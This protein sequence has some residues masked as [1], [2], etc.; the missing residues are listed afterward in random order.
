MAKR[1]ADEI[2]ADSGHHVDKQVARRS[3]QLFNLRANIQQ[4]PHIE[5]DMENAAVEEHGSYKSP[6]L[7][8]VVRQRQGRAQ[9]LQNVA[10]DSPKVEKAGETTSRH[11]KP[12]LAHCH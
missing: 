6:R 7:R 2:S 8:K 4:H 1:T 5:N 3:V 10:A 9:A 12:A 11:L